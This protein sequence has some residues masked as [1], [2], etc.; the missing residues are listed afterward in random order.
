MSD[1]ELRLIQEHE[2][3]EALL[4]EQRCYVPDAAATR[5]G[6][7]YRYEHYPNYFW[8]AWSGG[9]LA[10][11]AN[12]IR[13]SAWSCGD[14]MKGDQQDEEEGNNFCVLTVAVA[15]E[16]RRQGIGEKLLKKLVAECD[17]AGHEAILLMCER[18]LIPFYEKAGFAYI[19]V[20]ASAHGGI[21]WHEMRRTLHIMEHLTK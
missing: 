1:I 5:E 7:R 8:S 17:A 21:E 3:E 4:L 19:G 6:F 15:E 18:H 11:I 10:G 16:A 13:T 12:G 14:E 9:K 20:A 2:L